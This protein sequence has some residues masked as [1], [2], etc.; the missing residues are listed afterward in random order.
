MNLFQQFAPLIAAGVT[1][2]LKL[3]ANGENMQLDLIPV[4]KENKAG[5]SLS[6]KALVA[7]A[8]ELDEKLP[9]FLE[10]YLAS[11]VRISDLIDASQ[12]ELDAAEEA[13][14]AA[15][16]SAKATASKAPA[17]ATSGTRTATPAATKKP[18][19]MADG[20]MDEDDEADD[21]GSGEATGNGG[22]ADDGAPVNGGGAVEDK[23]TASTGEL[24]AALF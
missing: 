16:Q 17:K 2:H 7:T 24:S 9:A 8:A 14:K 3:S 18:R 21:T 19:N 22:G 15:A 10:T 13:A 20:L 4:A 5:I 23:T 12:K 1:V 6:P 11:Q